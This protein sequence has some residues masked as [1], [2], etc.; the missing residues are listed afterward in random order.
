M[1]RQVQEQ[2]GFSEAPPKYEGRLALDPILLDRAHLFG[3]LEAGV[4]EL[5]NSWMH[6]NVVLHHLRSSMTE[7]AIFLRELTAMVGRP[8]RVAVM[9]ELSPG[10]LVRATLARQRVATREEVVEDEETGVVLTIEIP[11]LMEED[12]RGSFGDPDQGVVLDESPVE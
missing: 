4:F 9:E 10:E 2:S 1:S 7:S 3:A 8:Y 5:S 12:E 6:Q 11:D